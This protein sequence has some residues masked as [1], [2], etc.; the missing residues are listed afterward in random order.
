M[1]TT[2]LSLLVL[3]LWLFFTGNTFG[4]DN[5][6]AGADKFKTC[7]SSMQST[8]DESMRFNYAMN[9]FLTEH[10]TTTQLQSA[11]HYLY[12]DQR[13]YELCVAAY[14]SIVD[15]EQFF[16]IYDVF[17]KFSYAIRLYHE[18]QEKQQIS[19]LQNNYQ[20]N[21]E[22]DND[23]IYDLLIQKG[24][25]LLSNNQ[26]D[27]AKVIYQ[28][29]QEIKP[30][31]PLAGE[32]LS[33]LEQMQKDLAAIIDSENQLNT[34]FDAFIYQGDVFLSSN[35]VDD[36]INSYEQAMALKPGDQIAYLRIKE[37]NQWKMELSNMSE[38]ENKKRAEYDFL[39]QKGD[40]FVSSNKYNEAIAV[41][42][43]ASAIYPEEQMPY[44]KIEE[45]S[46]LAQA[47][48]IC[49]TSEQSFKNIKKSVRDQIFFD[50]RF[51]MLKNRMNKKC[52]TV[53]QMKEMVK[54]F[55]MDNDK[56]TVIKYLYKYSYEQNRFY[57]FRTILTFNSTQKK[58]DAF[59]VSKN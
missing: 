32:K 21:V 44:A 42:Q 7:M 5:Q 37:A 1:K 27:E 43:Q 20:L 12:S 56:L 39:I 45:A 38:Q 40:I 3:S 26:F 9:Y 4:Q 49:T 50:D 54:V 33:N 17:S 36:A 59:L 47:D 51:V 53:E 15:K 25:L 18:T 2:T 55:N 10:T 31:D 16:D 57:E 22:E 34:Q 8:N 58:L 41:Y 52:F 30:S 46:R 24:D 19:T 6:W 29:A 11:C 35:Q 28:Q 23:A 48:S 14:P 13:K